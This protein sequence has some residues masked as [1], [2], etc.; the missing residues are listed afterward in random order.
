[1][2]SVATQIFSAFIV[3]DLLFTSD[4]DNVG[5]HGIRMEYDFIIGKKNKFRRT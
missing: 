5:S 2:W 4:M 3:M 1:M